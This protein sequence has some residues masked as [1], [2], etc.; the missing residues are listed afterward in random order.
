MS[1]D[2]AKFDMDLFLQLSDFVQAA[3]PKIME[4]DLVVIA[5]TASVLS[6]LMGCILAPALAKEPE[7]WDEAL[8][9]LRD[10]V[11][12]TA[13]SVLKIWMDLAGTTQ[14]LETRH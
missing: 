7:S 6:R 3:R 1:K 2:D 5:L 13:V 14:N 9:L 8:H 11:E 12:K 10:D 4:G